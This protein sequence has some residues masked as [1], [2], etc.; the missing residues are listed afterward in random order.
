MTFVEEYDDAGGLGD[1]CKGFDVVMFE[2]ADLVVGLFGGE[3]GFV[4]C[5]C[6]H[7]RRC[8]LDISIDR[9]SYNLNFIIIRSIT[10]SIGSGGLGN[11]L[12]FFFFLGGGAGAAGEAAAASSC[13]SSSSSAAASSSSSSS[14]SAEDGTFP[15][16]SSI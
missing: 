1:V 13:S 2:G 11:G 14:S 6:K 16:N 3:G 15:N 12:L 8:S 7:V 4:L 5:A 9:K 10:F